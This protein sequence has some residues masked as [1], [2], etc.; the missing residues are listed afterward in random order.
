MERRKDEGKDEKEGKKSA[1]VTERSNHQKI[2]IINRIN[3]LKSND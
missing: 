2:K 1:G 3:K